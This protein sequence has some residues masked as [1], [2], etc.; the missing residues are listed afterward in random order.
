MAD[1]VEAHGSTRIYPSP[2]T[3]GEARGEIPGVGGGG[4]RQDFRS[5]NFYRSSHRDFQPGRRRR[6][7]SR[8]W[9]GRRGS[10]AVSWQT[11]H[12]R[13][14]AARGMA[15]KGERRDRIVN[16]KPLFSNQ[17]I[18]SATRRGEA[19]RGAARSCTEEERERGPRVKRRRRKMAVVVGQGP[20]SR[21][22]YDQA[23]PRFLMA[24][25][26]LFYIRPIGIGWRSFT[27]GLNLWRVGHW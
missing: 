17:I 26:H 19:R 6:E 7:R 15:R 16:G 12:H 4:G 21:C 20:D 5:E 8:P 18:C 14:T 22:A 9:L 3:S 24:L 2:S 10:E 1:D 23:L 27:E 13:R 25:A 11:P